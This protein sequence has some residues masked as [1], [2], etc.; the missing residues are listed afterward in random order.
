M[1]LAILT[2][3]D[4]Q[5][6]SQDIQ[7][8]PQQRQSLQVITFIFVAL[9]F[10]LISFWTDLVGHSSAFASSNALV[11]PLANPRSFYLLGLICGA[12]LFALFP[13]QL[14]FRWLGFQ[15][16]AGVIIGLASFGYVFASTLEPSTGRLVA[17]LGLL[18]TGMGFAWLSIRLLAQLAQEERYSFIVGAIACGLFLKILLGAAIGP[19][20]PNAVQAAITVL[21]PFL[22]SL[23]LICAQLSL[24]SVGGA[25]DLEELPKIPKL[26]RRVLFLLLLMNSLLRAVIR[27][28]STMGFWGDGVVPASHL[29]IFDLVL[30]ALFFAAAAYFTLTRQNNPDLIVRFLPAFLVILAGFFI[31]DPQV[32]ALLR[33]SSDMAFTLN[34]FVELFAHLFFW[35]IVVFGIRSLSTHP[36]RVAGVAVALYAAASALLTFAM[37][38]PDV[39]YRLISVLALYVF[40]VVLMFAS[41]ILRTTHTDVENPSAPASAKGSSLRSN[42]DAATGDTRPDA[43]SSE[44]LAAARLNELARKGCLSPRETEVFLLLAQ[45]R[46]RPYIQQELFL[47]DGTVKTH[48]SRIYSKLG[49]TNRQELITLVQESPHQ[50]ETSD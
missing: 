27:V 33:L 35:V 47:A 22:T 40:I 43:R 44:N 17:I 6:L 32:L 12:A 1:I 9:G 50:Q 23:L 10:A 15:S 11:M 19:F 29:L 37:P 5:V 3:M 25:V 49:C 21:L 18:V 13:R 26:Q 16:V 2:P 20:T 36:F 24:N 48:I 30:L 41:R 4:T 38:N 42:P 14:D 28:M 7:H 31:L 45:G 34:I 39:A 46:S 8:Q